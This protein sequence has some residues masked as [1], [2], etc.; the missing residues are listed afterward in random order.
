MLFVGLKTQYCVFSV[1]K[2]SLFTVQPI[3]YFILFLVY[4]L[5]KR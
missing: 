3:V 5:D 4:G 1:F 2:H